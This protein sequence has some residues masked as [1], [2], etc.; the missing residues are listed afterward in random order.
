MWNNQCPNCANYV[1]V[2][3]RARGIC[4][5]YPKGIPVAIWVDGQ[6]HTKPF[7]GDHGIRF[8]KR[9]HAPESPV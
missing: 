8:E 5:A 9:K 7:S 1:G 3:G 2:I 4:L 6:D